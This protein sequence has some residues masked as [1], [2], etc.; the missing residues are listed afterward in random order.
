M[1]ER[2]ESKYPVAV[3][4]HY[5]GGQTCDETKTPRKSVVYIACCSD[6]KLKIKSLHETEICSYTIFMCSSVLCELG[7][8]EKFQRHDPYL[9]LDLLKAQCFRYKA[10]W[11][12]YEVCIGQTAKQYHVADGDSRQELSEEFSL[13]EFH[14]AWQAKPRTSIAIDR[15][16]T[17]PLYIDNTGYNPGLLQHYSGGKGISRGS[18]I[19]LR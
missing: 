1:A 17:S 4:Q 18:L 8:L 13:G 15:T 2:M 3:V 10:Q 14:N 11:W 16:A 12:T 19:K 7:F 6:A 5:E 9:G